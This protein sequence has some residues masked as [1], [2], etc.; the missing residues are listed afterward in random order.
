MKNCLRMLRIISKILLL[1]PF[2]EMYCILVHCKYIWDMYSLMY[3]YCKLTHAIMPVIYYLIYWRSLKYRTHFQS[4]II[5]VNSIIWYPMKTM[6]MCFEIYRSL[7]W[8]YFWYRLV[9]WP[10]NYNHQI[11]T[12]LL[13][14]RTWISKQKFWLVM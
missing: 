11:L 8:A 2:N 3:M 5:D 10:N 4:W 7:I 6:K 9:T 1:R 14:T 12:N 13:C